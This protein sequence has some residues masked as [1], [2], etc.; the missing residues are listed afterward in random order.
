MTL[1]ADA[2]VMRDGLGAAR[3][4]MRIVTGRARHRSGAG[5]K[6]FRF[7]KT[8]CGARDFK[9]VVMTGIPRVI[10]M[11]HVIRKRLAW[12][13]RKHTAIETPHRV[14]QRRA[15]RFEMTLHADLKLTLGREL[16]RIHNVRRTGLA[17][18]RAAGTVTALA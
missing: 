14:R 13:K 5:H 18:V 11:H 3:N 15:R 1:L 12:T 4:V 16:R 17:R 8:V 10:E 2:D 7:S 6:T 9:L